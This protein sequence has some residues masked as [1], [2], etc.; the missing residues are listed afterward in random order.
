M[1][2]EVTL[3]Q[4]MQALELA[5]MAGHSGAVV[6]ILSTVEGLTPHQLLAIADLKPDLS[7]IETLRETLRRTPSNQ[8]EQP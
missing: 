1:S 7:T 4:V 5:F 8:E 2:T 6:K 3:Q